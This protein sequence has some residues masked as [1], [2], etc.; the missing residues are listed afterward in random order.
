MPYAL[1]VCLQDDN[2]IAA[3][4]MDPDTGQ[5]SPRDEVP[6]AGGPSVMVLS[7]DLQ[8]LHVGTR[9]QP[10]ISTYRIDQATG[11]LKLQGTVLTEHAPT[12]LAPDRTGRY[13]LSAYYQA[14]FVAVH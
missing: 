3:F 11:G 2:K 10:A 12:F 8:M 9:T 13:V 1:D 6:V 5:L 7:P 14:G 4:G